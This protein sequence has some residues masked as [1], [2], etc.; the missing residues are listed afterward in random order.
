M[1]K[2]S[3]PNTQDFTGRGWHFPPSF[4]RAARTVVMTTKED[5]IRK[6]LEILLTTSVGERVMLP[7]Y[8]CDL[9]ELVLDSLDTTAKTLVE[10]RIRTAILYF[11]PRIDLVSVNLTGGNELEGELLIHISYAIRATNS[12]FN[13]VF[14]FY[15]REGTEVASFGSPQPTAP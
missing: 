9:Q 11:E 10:D 4:D 8:G 3:D 7:K 2:G 1:A 12:R 6:S 14:P 13:F 5:D 15:K